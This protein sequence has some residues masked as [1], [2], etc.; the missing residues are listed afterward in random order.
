MN[1]CF[2]FIDKS[3]E[4]RILPREY[5]DRLCVHLGAVWWNHALLKNRF[6]HICI[7]F[8]IWMLQI[9]WNF[10]HTSSHLN[11]CDKIKYLRTYGLPAHRKKYIIKW[12]KS[13]A[14]LKC[15]YISFIPCHWISYK[16][17]V[18]LKFNWFQWVRRKCKQR[19]CLMR[20]RA[21]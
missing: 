5:Y 6:M 4:M 19:R 9:L 20:K 7:S 8:C 12:I 3:K 11:M 21:N 15:A 13:I 1:L 18:I 17:L 16:M 2:N 14:V 10:L